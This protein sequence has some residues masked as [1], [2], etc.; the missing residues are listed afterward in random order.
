MWIPGR[1]DFTGEK[2]ARQN[3]SFSHIFELPA[4]WGDL[5]ACTF[6]GWL[7]TKDD[8][9]KAGEFDITYFKTGQYLLLEIAEVDFDVM[10]ELTAGRMLEYDIK[11]IDGSTA[12]KTIIEGDFE[13]GESVTE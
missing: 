6:T 2:R 11:M 8:K 9:T 12:S 7:R 13:T 10:Y 4:D 5:S 1:E 3:R